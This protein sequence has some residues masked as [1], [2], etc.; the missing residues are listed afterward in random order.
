MDMTAR[1]ARRHGERLWPA[2][3]F[4]L[5]NLLFLIR[6]ADRDGYEGDD[7][8]SILPM[9]HL[10][11]A[12]QGL[13]LIYRYAWQPL[14][15]EVG[16]ILWRLFDTPTAVFVS[17]PVAGA[18]SLALLLRIAQVEAERAR[19]GRYALA[20]ALVALAAVPEFWFSALFYNSTILGMP[21][22][23]GA[24]L[25][26][27]T[28]R[29]PSAAIAAG[30]LFGASILMR[31]DF[32]LIAPLLALVAWVGG[33]RRA[34]IFVGATVA[35][36][37]LGWIAGIVDL[38][39][40][41]DIQRSSAAEIQARAHQLGWDRRMKLGVVSICLAPVGW[42]LLV[43]GGPLLIMD[44]LKYDRRRLLWLVAALPTLYPLLNI[45]SPKYMLPLALLLP[46]LFV[47]AQAALAGRIGRRVAV[48]L[49]ALVTAVPLFVSISLYG[50][51]PFVALGSL[52][53]RPVGTHDGQRSYGGY[54]WQAMAVDA[55]TA[56]SDDQRA[57]DALATHLTGN[58]L[59]V[60]GENY[61]DRGGIAWRHL[62]L[63]MER[64]GA[65]GALIAPHQLRFSYHHALVTL[66]DTPPL[67][68]P[69]DTQLI[70][71]RGPA[72]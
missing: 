61:F 39:A 62:Q 5:L 21:F 50:H 35:T 60:G 64:E 11:A 3:L 66:A 4:L 29:R 14:A 9:A 57:A 53:D 71:L 20:A 36:L 67:R 13:L 58:T 27:R 68:L 32:I 23:A 10:A 34:A 42:L 30:L 51:R 48:P 55:P 41:A 54:L 1:D 19:L 49:L 56:Y 33:I 22:A 17:A 28:E 59:I 45:L 65:H 47:H 26:L 37:I 40:M 46:M 63:R 44:A 7:L 18:V 6:F 8:N 69:S 52:A 43:A 70:D 38:A 25:L 72:S 31:V 12:K 16:A 15:Y 24:L 2:A